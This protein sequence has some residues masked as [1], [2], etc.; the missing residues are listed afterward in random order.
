EKA[1]IRRHSTA[2]LDAYDLYLRARDLFRWSGA[3]DPRE[4]GE[5]ALRLLEDAIARDPQFALAHS[6]ASR[7]HT[8]LYWFGY[9]RNNDRLVKAK[10]EADT[11]LRLRP[12]LSEARLALA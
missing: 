11:A 9:D 7:F 10:R 3:G 8:E 5:K 1:S 4:N 6:L 2:D 12:D